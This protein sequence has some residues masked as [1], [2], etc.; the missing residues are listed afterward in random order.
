MR[1][2]SNLWV[3]CGCCFGAGDQQKWGGHH[4]FWVGTHTYQKRLEVHMVWFPFLDAVV[5]YLPIGWIATKRD[6][7]C[8]PELAE[9]PKNPQH[10]PKMD[11]S[12][13]MQ[14]K[15]W[16]NTLPLAM[17]LNGLRYHNMNIFLNVEN[18]LVV[19][20]MILRALL[21]VALTGG[22]RDPPSFA[23][24]ALTAFP[25]R[26][27]AQFPHGATSEGVTLWSRENR[28]RCGKVPK[29]AMRSLEEFRSSLERYSWGKLRIR[30]FKPL[31][32]Q[33]LKSPFFCK[34]LRK[35]QQDGSC[36]GW[37]CVFSL[38]EQISSQGMPVGPGC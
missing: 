30:N 1:F 5:E 10:G 2:L 8:K 29:N 16:L 34:G 22:F 4:F 9:H 3:A 13:T 11:G 18:V 28:W 33:K 12:S 23:T 7:F 17:K 24:R 31:E 37:V 25:S 35:G 20:F 15:F 21:S 27:T 14:A 26:Q 19:H 38:P 32:D 6:I 36:L